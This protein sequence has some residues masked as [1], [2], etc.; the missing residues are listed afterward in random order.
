MIRN[1]KI[2]P[3]NQR[4]WLHRLRNALLARGDTAIRWLN[5]V[6]MPEITIRTGRIPYEKKS[7][8]GKQ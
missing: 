3:E 2:I 7:L 8:I 4:K 6:K 5:G 1:K